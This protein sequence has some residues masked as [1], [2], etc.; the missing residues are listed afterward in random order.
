MYV[1]Q[2]AGVN[3]AWNQAR[4]Y[5]NQWGVE[6]GSRNGPVLVAPGPVI[7]V[8]ANPLERVLA[9]PIRNA[10]P[11]LHLFESFWLLAGRE[12]VAFIAQFAANMATFSDD[13][14]VLRGAYGYRWRKAFGYDQLKEIVT[15]LRKNH[16]DRRC[17]LQMWHSPIDMPWMQNTVSKDVPCNTQVYFTINPATKKLD[18]TVCCRSNDIVW[19]AYGANAV[20]FSILQEYMAAQIG[21]PVGTFHQL[22]NNW[23]AYKEVWKKQSPI[24]LPLTDPYISEASIPLFDSEERYTVTPIFGHRPKDVMLADDDIENITAPDYYTR[25]YQNKF[26]VD[27]AA[28]MRRAWEFYK[29]NDLESAMYSLNLA[30]QYGYADSDWLLNGLAWLERIDKAR[31]AKRKVSTIK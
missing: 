20:H 2:T 1:I 29:A 6:N 25:G 22:S 14:K 3:G 16:D 28:P 12:D 4:D 26:F 9:D 13:G 24:A 17:V 8:Y 19:G 7:T 31:S 11:F 21:V 5:L 10:N 15:R 30:Q 23:H 18:M 27:V